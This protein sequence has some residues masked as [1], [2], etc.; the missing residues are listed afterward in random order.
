MSHRLDDVAAYHDREMSPE[1]NAEFEAHLSTCAECQ[2]DLRAARAALGSYDAV[3]SA[4]PAPFDADAAMA[5]LRQGQAQARRAR[6]RRRVVWAGSI[7]LAA[8]AAVLVAVA[9]L[10]G[11][12][13]PRPARTQQFAPVRPRAAR[14]G[15]P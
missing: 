8:A 3:V 13:A 5:R 12:P 14:D 6:L 15:G 2:T 1:Q 11:R 10:A 4:R 7:G 9:M